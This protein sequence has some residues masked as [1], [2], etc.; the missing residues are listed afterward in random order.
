VAY[1][2]GAVFYAWRGFPYHHAVWHLFVLAG[3]ALHYLCVL[4]FVIPPEVAGPPWLDSDPERT[5]PKGRHDKNQVSLGCEISGVLLT[6]L[7]KFLLAD[8]LGW[9]LIFIVAACLF[10]VGFVARRTRAEPSVLSSWGFTSRGLAQASPAA[11]VRGARADRD[12]YVWYAL[13][14]PAAALAHGV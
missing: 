5:T 9:R 10:W 2:A 3:T 1:S 14:A 4:R 13:R 8:W 6:G 12:R 11:A 7:G